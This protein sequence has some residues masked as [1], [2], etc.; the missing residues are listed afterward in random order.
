[1]RPLPISDNFIALSLNISS[2]VYSQHVLI[3]QASKRTVSASRRIIPNLRM[4]YSACTSVASPSTTFGGVLGAAN[5]DLCTTTP[6]PVS[7]TPHTRTQEEHGKIETHGSSYSWIGKHAIVL[8]KANAA[9]KMNT[10]LKAMAHEST[11][12]SRSSGSSVR[13]M[14]VECRISRMSCM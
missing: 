2:M 1:M 12:A 14:E 4:S 3:S 8:K 7:P 9:L 6:V 11:A 5:V 10:A 13:M